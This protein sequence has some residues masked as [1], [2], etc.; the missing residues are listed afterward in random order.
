M[1]DDLPRIGKF[2]ACSQQIELGIDL[3]GLYLKKENEAVLG[4]VQE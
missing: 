1:F 2:Q 4:G 3:E